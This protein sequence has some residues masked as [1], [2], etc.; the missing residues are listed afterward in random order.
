M[1]G[2]SYT[3]ARTVSGGRPLSPLAKEIYFCMSIFSLGMGYDMA[4][5]KVLGF[6]PQTLWVTLPIWTVLL[7]ILTRWRYQ[8]KRERTGGQP[9]TR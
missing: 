9:P 2:V 3:I 7:L 8:K 5:T 1:Y 6:S 4:L